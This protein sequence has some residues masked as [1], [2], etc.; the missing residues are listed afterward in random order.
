MRG[1]LMASARAARLAAD[2]AELWIPA[3][4]AA[5]G[6]LGWLPLVLAVVPLPDTAGLTF[7][8]A[9]LVSS[10]DYPL[11]A[12]LLGLA[13]LF[14]LLTLCLLVAIGEAALQRALRPLLGERRAERDSLTGET[15]VVFVII[16]VALLPA[17]TALL[18]LALWVAAV[19][20]GEFM[21]PD[22]GG[23]PM[24]RV[25]LDVLPG[26]VIAGAVAIV[27][28]AFGGAVERRAIGPDAEPLGRAMLG[29]IADLLRRP[30]TVAGTLVATTAVLVVQLA[31]STLLL[32][33]LWAPIG[34]A[35][36]AGELATP[37]TILLLVGFTAIWLCLLL[38]GGALHAWASAWWSLELRRPTTA[39]GSAAT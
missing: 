15:S 34:A 17:G 22:I 31:L 39:E 10:G 8:G 27:A 1:W 19:A 6:F 14:G 23:T 37:S 30:A 32:R 20:P 18:A 25:V 38:A 29:G 16:L 28:Q 26:I 2:R 21:S 7:F 4:L 5:L 12:V 24:V 36:D 9:D 33:V 11:N 13:G 35:L 3:S